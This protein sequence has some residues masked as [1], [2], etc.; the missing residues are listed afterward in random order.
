[1]S[2]KKEYTNG[3]VTV[4]WEANK[5]VHSGVCVRGLPKVFRPK[6]RPWVRIQA[7]DTNAIINQVK[8][9]PSGALH[10]YLNGETKQATNPENTKVEVMNNGPLLVHGTLE[11]THKDGRK[12]LKQKTTAFCRCGS[13]N[14]KPFCDGSHSKKGFV[15]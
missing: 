10:Y 5:C 14:N 12:E 15:D 11:V 4:V 7:A 9:C 2:T 6:E 1:M 8:H 13:S 3:E